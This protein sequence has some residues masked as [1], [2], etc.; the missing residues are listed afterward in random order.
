MGIMGYLAHLGYLV[1]MVF[2]DDLI[3]VGISVGILVGNFSETFT[4]K[5]QLLPI[6]SKVKPNESA[7][8]S[9]FTKVYQLGALVS[10][11][12]G[13]R[14]E[15]Y[16]PCQQ[17]RGNLSYR[18]VPFFVCLGQNFGFGQR[19]PTLMSNKKVVDMYGTCTKN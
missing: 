12:V 3:P 19:L 16:Y 18:E 13:C 10:K 4:D 6:D 1:I 2:L 9:T 7:P 8:F 15:S 11:T 5:D 17:T 14:F